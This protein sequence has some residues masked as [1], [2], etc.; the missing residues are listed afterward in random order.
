MT[1]EPKTNL[2]Y[3]TSSG[4]FDKKPKI[5]WEDELKFTEHDMSENEQKGVQI[6]APAVVTYELIAVGFDREQLRD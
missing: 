1:I 4:G 6:D 3:E 2:A 5:F